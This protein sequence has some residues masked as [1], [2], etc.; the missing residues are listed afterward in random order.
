M[1]GQTPAG[2]F[3]ASSP[4]SFTSRLSLRVWLPTQASTI[5]SIGLQQ[6]WCEESSTSLVTNDVFFKAGQASAGGFTAFLHPSPSRPSPLSWLL[7]QRS[8]IDSIGLASQSCIKTSTCLVQDDSFF[9][10]FRLQFAVFTAL[11]YSAPSSQS[12][13]TWHPKF[14]H[15]PIYTMR[16]PASPLMASPSWAPIDATPTKG[17]AIGILATPSTWSSPANPSHGSRQHLSTVCSCPSI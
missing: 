14:Q 15:F 13:H 8:T 4:P 16:L 6:Q 1:A 12:L 10:G 17:T 9:K 5:G 3:T 11:R 2:G 7:N